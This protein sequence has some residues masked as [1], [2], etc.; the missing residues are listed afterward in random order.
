ML[1]CADHYAGD[2]SVSLSACLAFSLESRL[3]IQSGTHSTKKSKELKNLAKH[4]NRQLHNAGIANSQIFPPRPRVWK[5]P[6]NIFRGG[7]QARQ[8]ATMGTTVSVEDGAAVESLPTVEAA[9]SSGGNSSIKSQDDGTNTLV[10][11]VASGDEST[12]IV[13]AKQQKK[14]S[15]GKKKKKNRKGPLGSVVGVGMDVVQDDDVNVNLAMADLMAYLQLVA[16][17]SQDLPLTRRDDPELGK[18]V[19]TLSAKDYLK[20]AE[21]FLPCDVRVIGGS[22]TKY[23]RIR[24][25]PSSEVSLFEEV[26]HS[27][28]ANF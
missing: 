8:K 20:R 28:C 4:N 24:E 19:C 10:S 13:S 15:S 1:V 18:T 14:R 6:Q 17:N 7:S 5:F 2:L 27:S 11:I 3:S 25:L 21:A 9:T 12:A 16:A 22:F 26:A 23:G